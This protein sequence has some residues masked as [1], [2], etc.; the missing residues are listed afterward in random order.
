MKIKPSV[1]TVILILFTLYF[2]YQTYDYYMLKEKNWLVCE[3]INDEEPDSS[4]YEEGTEEYNNE[5]IYIFSRWLHCRNSY[6]GS[7]VM[8]NIQKSFTIVFII[9]TILALRFDCL[10]STKR[11]N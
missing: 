4:S 2:A 3:E 8:Y 5:K 10:N 7:F 11:N 6:D 1:L 9:L